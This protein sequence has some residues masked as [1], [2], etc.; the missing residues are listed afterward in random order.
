MSAFVKC[1][2]SCPARAIVVFSNSAGQKLAFCQSHTN[3]MEASLLA[4]GF[5]GSSKQADFDE[6]V[7][8]QRTLQAL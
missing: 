4:D 2:A 7:E 5:M 3:R 8:H 1:D 6:L